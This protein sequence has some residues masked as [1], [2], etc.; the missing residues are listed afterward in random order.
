MSE[1]VSYIPII[2]IVIGVAW[3]I[4]KLQP[5]V[6]QVFVAVIGSLFASAVLGIAPE[7]IKPSTPGEGGMG[8]SIILAAS[9]AIIAVPTCLI[10]MIIF[11]FAQRRNKAK[12]AN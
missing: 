3:A 5:I 6:F 2:I 10:S 11:N 1:F 12:K 4:R 8:W 9:Y 7:I